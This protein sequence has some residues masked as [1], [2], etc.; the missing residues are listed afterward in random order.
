MVPQ[1]AESNSVKAFG[2]AIFAGSFVLSLIAGAV[3]LYMVDQAAEYNFAKAK[4][5][6]ATI[7][8]Q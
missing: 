6:W 5:T 1:A 2:D 7:P 3:V 8:G 4:A